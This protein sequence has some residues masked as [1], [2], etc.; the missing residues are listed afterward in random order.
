MNIETIKVVINKDGQVELEV[1]GAHGP[2]CVAITA[3]IVKMLGGEIIS[4]DFTSEYDEEQG[5]TDNISINT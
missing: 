3:D 2:I 4:Q 5:L 1:N